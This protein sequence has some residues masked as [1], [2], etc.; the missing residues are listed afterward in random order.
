M[1]RIESTQMNNRRTK[2][3]KKPG[4]NLPR[5]FNRNSGTEEK[6]SVEIPVK[7][8]MDLKVETTD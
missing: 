7:R 1:K 3:K 6:T 4:T 8:K 2:R 5:R